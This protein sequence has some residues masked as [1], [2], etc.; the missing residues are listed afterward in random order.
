MFCNDVK[1][2][3]FRPRGHCVCMCVRACV[4]AGIATA[5]AVSGEKKTPKCFCNIFYKTRTILTKFGL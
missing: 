3:G 4:Y 5:R 1:V 2:P